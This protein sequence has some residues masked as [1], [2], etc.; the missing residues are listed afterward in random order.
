MLQKRKRKNNNNNTNKFSNQNQQPKINNVITNDNDRTF[1]VGPKYSSETF[2]MLEVLSRTP[3][4]DVYII[5]KSSP[6]QY[7]NYKTKIKK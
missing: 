4:R 7:S 2:P 1:L 6:E 3:D 5:T